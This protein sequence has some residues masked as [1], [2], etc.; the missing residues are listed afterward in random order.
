MA[1]IYS[2]APLGTLGGPRDGPGM[3][4]YSVLITYPSTIL[5]SYH[6]RLNKYTHSLYGSSR[7]GIGVVDRN[8]DK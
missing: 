8:F 1:I 5:N 7:P 2:P 4:S 3:T 6:Q